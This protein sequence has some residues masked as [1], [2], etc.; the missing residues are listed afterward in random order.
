MS[1]EIEVVKTK[2]IVLKGDTRHLKSFLSGL[3]GS[4]WDFKNKQ[5]IV[6]YEHKK[7]LRAEM[8]KPIEELKAA[9]EENEKE[10][11]QITIYQKKG[12]VFIEGPTYRMRNY[13]RVKNGTFN[14][15]TKTWEF[16]G[17]LDEVVKN[18]NLK[19]KN[20]VVKK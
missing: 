13:L 17:E 5:W 14:K 2:F 20:V 7:A 6:P 18:L 15:E 19:G 1:S 11:N 16:V 9:A 4:I 10:K 8:K 12:K 3:E